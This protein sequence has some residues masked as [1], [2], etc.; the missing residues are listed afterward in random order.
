METIES[1]ERKRL[2]AATSLLA[3]TDATNCQKVQ[4]YC[5]LGT[6]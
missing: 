3:S 2:E 6:F 1:D 4:S 5:V